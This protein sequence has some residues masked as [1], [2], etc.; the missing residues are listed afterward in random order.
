[1]K[2]FLGSV[3]IEP[4]RWSKDRQAAVNPGDWNTAMLDA[5]FAGW[6]LWEFH[7]PAFHPETP[8]G[9]PVEIY[10]TYALPEDLS[11]EA[12]SNLAARVRN[13]GARAVKFNLGKAEDAAER[14]RP[15]VLELLAA[16]PG[17]AFWC[18]CHP[19]TV[20]EDTAVAIPW[21]ESLPPEVGVILHPF[22]GDPAPQRAWFKHAPD[23][24]RH[25]HFQIQ[26]PETRKRVLL[27]TRG[28]FVNQRLREL[29][30]L[31]YKGDATQEFTLGVGGGGAT[32]ETL[33]ANAC[34]DLGFLRAAG[35]A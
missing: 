2:V 11:D 10:N 21:I 8:A 16:C 27:E 14:A 18:E 4:K 5:G 6:E 26:H 33:F 19:G 20:L 15:R 17:V 28:D 3:L 7:D 13:S 30:D 22:G 9:L 24:V 29:V 32:P 23:R 12:L 34:R 31:G 1:M 25:L 35:W